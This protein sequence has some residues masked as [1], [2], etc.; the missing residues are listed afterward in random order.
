MERTS[1]RHGL[2]QPAASPCASD[3]SVSSPRRETLAEAAGAG[4]EEAVETMPGRRRR[5]GG[6][7]LSVKETGNKQKADAD[8]PR[9]GALR[10]A[11]GPRR[12]LFP[13]ATTEIEVAPPSPFP[14]SSRLLAKNAAC[15]LGGLAVS[16]AG[17]AG[18]EGRLGGQQREEEA[19][20][21]PLAGRLRQL[22][23]EGG[24]GCLESEPR[25]E[26]DA[27]GCIPEAFAAR[28]QMME[29]TLARLQMMEHTLGTLRE[30]MNNCRE[31]MAASPV[32]GEEM[33]AGNEPI[34][35]WAEYL[36][37]GRKNNKIG[38]T[39]NWKW[40]ISVI[41]FVSGLVLLIKFRTLLP[42]AYLTHI[43]GTIAVLWILGSIAFCRRLF[44]ASRTMKG[45]SH[46]VSRLGYVCFSLLVLYVMYLIS[47]H[48]CGTS[49]IGL[50]GKRR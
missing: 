4:E 48:V 46:H 25:A 32:Q 11:L 34:D 21:G 17:P 50:L 45:F 29:H 18:L 13:S 31:G 5:G 15:G 9:A 41:A 44:G 2:L 10:P 14:P 30:T 12:A 36:E 37:P 3:S 33:L 42:I 49:I 19:A 39:C 27:G 16:A 24:E 40:T 38:R 28:L 35:I 22:R 26:E 8:L 1:S 23:R 43:V 7:R 20:L 6:G 47:Q